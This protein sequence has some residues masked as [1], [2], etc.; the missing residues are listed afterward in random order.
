MLA[1]VEHRV[2]SQTMPGA[3]HLCTVQADV[4]SVWGRAFDAV[5]VLAHEFDHEADRDA[6]WLG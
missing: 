6:N 1:A 2:D 4:Y 3:V 5:S